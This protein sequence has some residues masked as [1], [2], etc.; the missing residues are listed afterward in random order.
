M[1]KFSAQIIRQK[2]RIK[3]LESQIKQIRAEIAQD[4]EKIRKIDDITTALERRC[5]NDGGL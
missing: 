3:E 5:V 4:E 2:A 1:S